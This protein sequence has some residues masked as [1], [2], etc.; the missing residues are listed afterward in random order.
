MRTHRASWHGF[1][2]RSLG[3]GVGSVASS[4]GPTF[5]FCSWLLLNSSCDHERS[6]GD[7]SSN[8]CQID[9]H[10]VNRQIRHGNQIF[11]VHASVLRAMDLD[12]DH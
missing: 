4:P 9:F 12:S 3:S 8:P 1:M 7:Q 2:H 6:S 5:Q 10:V 11:S